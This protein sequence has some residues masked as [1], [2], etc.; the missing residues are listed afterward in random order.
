MPQ[1][2]TSWSLYGIEG[3]MMPA[4][5]IDSKSLINAWKKTNEQELFI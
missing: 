5:G 1:H 4:A 3:V 2:L